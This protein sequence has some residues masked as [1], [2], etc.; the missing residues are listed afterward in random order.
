MTEKGRHSSG[1]YIIAITAFFLGCF[2]LLVVFGTGIYRSIA[3]RQ[4]ANNQD[5]AVLAYLLTVTKMNENDIYINE[6]PDFGN[7]LIVEDAGTGYG[8][9]IY[10]NE[11]YLVEDYGRA[12][13]A[14]MPDYATRIGESSFLEAEMMDDDLYKLTTDHGSVFVHIREH[15]E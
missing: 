4:S 15:A 2:L 3:S 1:I 12:E 5:R 6:D 13:G 14:L 9:R 11:G 7:V 10:I 8:N